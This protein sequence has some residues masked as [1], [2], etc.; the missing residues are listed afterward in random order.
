MYLLLLFIIISIAY[1]SDF[2]Y[3]YS[4]GDFSYNQVNNLS[5]IEFLTKDKTKS[6]NYGRYPEG[7]SQ[8]NKKLTGRL[9]DDK[10]EFRYEY[11]LIDG[12]SGIY[13]STLVPTDISKQVD[14]Y[15]LKDHLIE[16]KAKVW[17]KVSK[18]FSQSGLSI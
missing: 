10:A 9:I 18:L 4:K 7:F 16:N 14:Y 2:F 1:L 13:E 8:Y 11:P 15:G 12:N 3:Y 6:K 17:I 5:L